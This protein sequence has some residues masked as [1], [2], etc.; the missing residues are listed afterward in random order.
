MIARH[1]IIS[2]RVQGVGY[3]EWLCAE[4]EARGLRGWVRNRFDG[5]VEALL[6]GPAESVTAV[7]V[8]CHS[9]PRMASVQGVTQSESAVPDSAEFRRLPSV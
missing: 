9:G 6:A 1:L 7:I 3:R 2:G 4:A 5:T 8:A